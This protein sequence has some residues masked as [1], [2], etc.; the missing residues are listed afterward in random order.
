MREVSFSIVDITLSNFSA[1]C[2]LGGHW[3][4]R[5]EEVRL[6]SL[7][8]NKRIRVAIVTTSFGSS[9]FLDSVPHNSQLLTEMVM[10][11]LAECR[12]DRSFGIKLLRKPK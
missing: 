4:G 10:I 6:R 7:R 1:S 5:S 3:A 11:S 9:P 2:A 8:I 12:A